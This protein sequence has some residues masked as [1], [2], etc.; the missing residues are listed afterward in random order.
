LDRQQWEVSLAK[1]GARHRRLAVDEFR[2]PLRR[3]SEVVGRQRVDSSAAAVLRF[4]DGNSLAGA[5]Q[6]ASGRQAR[7]TRTDNCDV[8]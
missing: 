6:L 8:V 7:G 5:T 2:T 1:E 3:I 4:E